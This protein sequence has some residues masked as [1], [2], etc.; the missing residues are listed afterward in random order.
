MRFVRVLIISVVIIIAG[1]KIT[2]R[3]FVQPKLNQKITELI[4]DHKDKIVIE[5]LRVDNASLQMLGIKIKDTRDSFTITGMIKSSLLGWPSIHIEL[6][7]SNST[8]WSIHKIE[9]MVKVWFNKASANK[10][11]IQDFKLLNSPTFSIP[12][13]FLSF[14][15]Q[16]STPLTHIGLEIPQFGASPS[17]GQVYIAGDLNPHDQFSG[18]LSLRIINPAAVLGELAKTE[19]ISKQQLSAINGLITG[20]SNNKSEVTLPL[21]IEK[22]ALYLGPIRLYP[23]S[24]REDNLARIGEGVMNNLFRAFGKLP[25]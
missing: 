17:A 5:S 24:S 19:L 6:F 25:Q 18:K 3:Y 15:Y 2:E 13:I 21:S 7:P 1:L 4:Q 22:G 11:L 20:L 12:Q 10:I 23:K 14:D 9:G 8:V 16:T